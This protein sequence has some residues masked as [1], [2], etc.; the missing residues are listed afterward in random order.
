M[1]KY[2]IIKSFYR[3]LKWRKFRNG[4]IHERGPVCEECGKVLTDPLDCEV[5][6]DPI[7]LTPENV[8]DAS[9]SL[10]PANVKVK[11]NDC[12]NKRHHRFGHQ[13][14][15][16]VY[17]VYGPPLSGKTS[18]VIK[19][20]QRGDLVVDMD[21]L[22]QAV[23]LQP[24]YDKPNELLVN[25]LGIRNLLIDNVKTRY[26]RWNSAWIIGGYPEKYRREQL[27]DELGAELIYCEASKEEC[28]SRL[29]ADS[30]RRYR[31]NEWKTYIEKWFN[32]Y[33]A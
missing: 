15:H 4:I 29:A 13:A 25:V 14:E 28:M 21:K 23:S 33:V 31:Q 11:C 1:A 32:S 26:G 10:N 8:N 22:Y 12:H 9:V 19:N 30:D 17:I 27:S 20:M 5:D 3:S 24:E 18:Y 16:G 6:H 2:A 7:E